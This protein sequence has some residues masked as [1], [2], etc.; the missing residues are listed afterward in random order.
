MKRKWS[1]VVGT[2]SIRSALDSD[3]GEC[4]MIATLMIE[5]SIECSRFEGLDDVVE[6]VWIYCDFAIVKNVGESRRSTFGKILP[7]ALLE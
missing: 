5:S 7:Q 2:R 1:G 6:V 4:K 3:S